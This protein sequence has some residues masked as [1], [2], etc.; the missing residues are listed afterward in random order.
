MAKNTREPVLMVEVIG[1]QPIVAKL[2]DISL[3]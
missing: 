3:L 1:R 2:P